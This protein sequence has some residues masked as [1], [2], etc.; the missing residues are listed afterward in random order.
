MIH[1]GSG[2]DSR[3]KIFSSEDPERI[4]P[5]DAVSALLKCDK[6]IMRRDKY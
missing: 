1:Q 2:I 4:L 6:L 5:S 3:L